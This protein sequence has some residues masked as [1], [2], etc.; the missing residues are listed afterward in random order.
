MTTTKLFRRGLVLLMLA[1]GA[2]S[3]GCSRAHLSSD[4]GHSFS[5]WFAM[6]HVRH[7]PA[8]SESTKRALGH[9]DAQEAAAISRNYRRNVGGGTEAAGQMVM[10]GTA[11]HGGEGY[12]PPPS[13]PGGQ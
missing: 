6:Q 8:D 9:L 10:T 3:A 12:T 11:Q 2:A 5:S 4:Y 7:E 1:G 13:V